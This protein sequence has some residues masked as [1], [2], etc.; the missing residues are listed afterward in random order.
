MFYL[1]NVNKEIVKNVKK[2][3]FLIK[4]NYI[5]FVVDLVLFIL[6][7]VVVLKNFDWFI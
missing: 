6:I 3:N 7:I 1:W 5:F 4:C 2:R